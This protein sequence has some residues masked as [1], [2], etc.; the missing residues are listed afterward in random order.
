MA[1]S[2]ILS[3]IKRKRDMTAVKLLEPTIIKRTAHLLQTNYEKETHSE[4][5]HLLRSV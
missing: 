5:K 3:G 2:T 1:Q 4:R